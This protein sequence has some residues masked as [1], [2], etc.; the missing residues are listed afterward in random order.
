MAAQSVTLRTFVG[1]RTLNPSSPRCSRRSAFVVSAV[2]ARSLLSEARAARGVEARRRPSSSAL[3]APQRR[4]CGTTSLV[5][6]RRTQHGARCRRSVDR[7]REHPSRLCVIEPFPKT[8]SHVGRGSARESHGL[9]DRQA[10]HA[11]RARRSR[12]LSIEGGTALRAGHAGSR[13][14]RCC[15][16]GTLPESRRAPAVASTLDDLIPATLVPA[17]QSACERLERPGGFA[18]CEPRVDSTLR[19]HLRGSRAPASRRAHDARLDDRLRA[20]YRAR[21]AQKSTAAVVEHP[22]A[23]RH[24][25][26]R[27]RADR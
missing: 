8:R 24:L 13:R 22:A 25:L 15:R 5:A 9:S 23:V 6:T 26:P 10:G 16:P 20:V 17:I 7:E 1:P 3:H 2:D 19:R 18:T 12:S 14:A 4:S 27:L 11:R 21:A